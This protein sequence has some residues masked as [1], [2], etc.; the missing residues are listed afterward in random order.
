ML[1]W[2]INSCFVCLPPAILVYLTMDSFLG[3][4]PA[5]PTGRT[6]NYALWS[7][8]AAVLTAYLVYSKFGLG[9]NRVMKVCAWA[10]NI[11]YKA[12]K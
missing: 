6:A 4:T 7:I 11:G 5:N 10:F 1:L 3:P 2:A 9:T 8:G 12:A